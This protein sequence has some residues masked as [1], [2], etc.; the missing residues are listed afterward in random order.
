MKKVIGLIKNVGGNIGGAV[1]N[2]KEYKN[3]EYKKGYY[4]GSLSNGGYN[5]SE[6]KS[7]S[8]EELIQKSNKNILTI[9][10]EK[11]IQ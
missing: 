5:Q 6:Q 10:E 2:K 4:Y 3:S 8:V 9:A 1:L 11:K 7:V